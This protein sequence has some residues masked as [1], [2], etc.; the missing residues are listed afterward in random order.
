MTA[1]TIAD[2]DLPDN[3]STNAQALRMIA[4]LR[5]GPVSSIEAAKALDI[6]HPPSTIRHLRRQGWG[7]LTR[8]CYQAAAPGRRPHRVGLYILDKEID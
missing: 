3:H 7:I 5:K 8:W 1:E 2:A 4:A 6:V